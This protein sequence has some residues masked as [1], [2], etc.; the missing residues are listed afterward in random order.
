VILHFC[1]RDPYPILDVRALWS[2]SAK[3]P[4][5]VDYPF[6]AEYTRFTRMLAA[7]AGVSLRV[8]DRALWQYSKENQH[9]A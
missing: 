1:A 3:P 8:L 6:W 7:R 4:A 9:G 2:V 5:H